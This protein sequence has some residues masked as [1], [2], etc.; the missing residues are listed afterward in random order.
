MPGKEVR[1]AIIRLRENG[2][3]HGEIA[4]ELRH[5]G[6]SKQTSFVFTWS[7]DFFLDFCIGCNAKR[8]TFFQ[9]VLKHIASNQVPINVM[10]VVE[11]L[12]V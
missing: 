10:L 8:D 12:T 5:V 9:R 3:S 2:Y 4:N 6:V 7:F 11:A 1:E